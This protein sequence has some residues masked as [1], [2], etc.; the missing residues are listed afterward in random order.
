MAEAGLRDLRPR[1]LAPRRGWE[2]PLAALR[3]TRMPWSLGDTRRC[4][5]GWLPLCMSWR[6]PDADD[7]VGN[8]PVPALEVRLP[9]LISEASSAAL[10]SL[11]GDA[12]RPRLGEP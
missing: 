4:A 12:E 8:R 7:T 2:T 1:D 6:L 10:L 11:D 5:N 3:D 9:W